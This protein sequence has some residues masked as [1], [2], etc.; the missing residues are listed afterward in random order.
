M[1][2]MYLAT[3]YTG[4]ITSL[5]LFLGWERLPSLGRFGYVEMI[6]FLTIKVLLS[7]RLST[8]IPGLFVYGPLYNA[9]RIE[10]CLRRCVHD[11]RLQRGILL[12]NMGGSM[13]LGLAPLCFRRYTDSTCFFAFPFFLCVC[14]RRPCLAACISVMQRPGAVLKSSK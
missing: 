6:S 8:D 7:C 4:L 2:L 14:M 11:W 13:I 9:W 5:E 10:T 12:S 1:L 3:G